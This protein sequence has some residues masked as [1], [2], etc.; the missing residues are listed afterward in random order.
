MNL[1][2]N[3][4]LAE[5]YS[6]NSQIARI[7][8]EQWVKENSYCPCCGELPLNEF[9]NNRPVADFY[10]I[11]CLEEFELKSKNGKLSNTI[12]DGAYA[13]MIERINSNNNPN[14]FFLTYTKEWSVNDFLI[15]PKQFFSPEIIIKRAALS[16]T[17]KRAGWV[18][19]NID[20][21]KVAD[22]G[23]VFLIKNSQIINQEIVTETFNKTLFLRTQKKESKGWILDTLACVDAIKK[24]CFSLDEI[25]KFEE[26]LRL[27]YPQNNFIK[28]KLRQQLQL[29]RDKGIIEFV[30]RG[31]YRKI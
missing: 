26:K 2:F 13:T 29:L 22:A 31:Q 18:G 5:G 11:K 21:S 4:K 28:D 7:L 10:C 17:A 25:Y 19:C 27:K 23:K 9:E 3:T 30:G 24:E 6:S 12:A 20:I 16:E 1:H 8:T 15:I 14:F